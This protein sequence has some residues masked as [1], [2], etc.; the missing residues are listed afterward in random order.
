MY[1]ETEQDS[2]GRAHVQLKFRRTKLGAI[3]DGNGM[4]NYN[5][6]AAAFEMPV[7]RIQQVVHL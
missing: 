6:A 3:Q 1:I 4:L 7:S 5:T 2:F